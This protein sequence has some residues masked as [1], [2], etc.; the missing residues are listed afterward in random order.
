MASRGLVECPG[1]IPRS[2]RV[3]SDMPAPPTVDRERDADAWEIARRKEYAARLLEDTFRRGFR[4]LIEDVPTWQAV[5]DT[6]APLA[7]ILGTA[8]QVIH[9]RARGVKPTAGPAPHVIAD[10]LASY[11]VTRFP[12]SSLYVEQSGAWHRLPGHRSG[13]RKDAWHV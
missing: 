9:W 13:H 12:L 11:V 8:G 2:L 5:G 10:A 1:G 6:P 7:L 3:V 4:V